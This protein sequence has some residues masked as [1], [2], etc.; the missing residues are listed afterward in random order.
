M[1]E[2]ASADD[3]ALLL[4][5]MKGERIAAAHPEA[6]IIASDQLLICDDK[7]YGKPRDMQAHQQIKQLAGR[8]HQLISAVILFDKGR[9]WH[10]IARPEITF[11]NLS[12]RIFLLICVMSGM[13]FTVLVVISLKGQAYIYLLMFLVI[14]MQ[15]WDCRC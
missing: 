14:I 15:S 10:H 7:I 2:G 8:R 1:H 13:L 3:I 4:A 12:M 11:H 9:V 5:E 6:L